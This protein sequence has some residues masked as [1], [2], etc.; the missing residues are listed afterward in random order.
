[1]FKKTTIVTLF[2]VLSFSFSLGWGAKVAVFPFE[3]FSY[4]GY[5]VNF[6]IAE[7]INKAIRSKG[8]KTIG[9]REVLKV[10]IKF[11]QIDVS[12]LSYSLLRSLYDKYECR[13]VL[14]GTIEKLSQSPAQ[15][16]LILRLV[17]GVSGRVVWGKVFFLSAKDQVSILGLNE[18][19]FKRLKKL[20]KMGI[21]QKF[22]LPKVAEEKPL[23][24]AIDVQEVIFSSKCVKPK[25][26]VK[27]LIKLYF[28]GERPYEL[29][30]KVSKTEV[31]NLT[32]VGN[33][34]FIASWVAPEEEK[35][36][37]VYLI[38]KWEKP[39]NT[40]RKIFVGSYWVDKTPP[41]LKL[42]VKGGLK[43]NGKIFVKDVVEIIP[44][45]LEENS[46]IFSPSRGIS[47]WM[48]T[49]TYDPLHK[50]VW[51]EGA[52]GSLP[53]LL[54]W[55]TRINRAILPA[56]KYTIKVF[57]WDLAGNEGVAE[58]SVILV[59]EPPAP[60][61]VI[62][63]SDKGPFVVV[64][65]HKEFLPFV[66]VKVKV[67]NGKNK[68]I[69]QVFKEGTNIS[70]IKEK[71]YFKSEDLI[72]PFYYDAVVEDQLKNEK[73]IKK[74]PIEVKRVESQPGYK[75]WVPEF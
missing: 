62:Y 72:P 31:V 65:L 33:G 46:G 51:S 12:K 50:K 16:F 3:D 27:C 75:T 57:A 37:A 26:S 53:S 22:K 10:L 47:K 71:I 25:A 58:K 7:L 19:T 38:A 68:V 73:I 40:K 36:Y 43:Q 64:E 11:R 55:D 56:G 52:P 66:K 35:K 63:K 23:S 67:Y 6:K 69:A 45:L 8:I 21:K 41:K 14:L 39:L 74:E 59:K 15:L 42:Y 17:D 48:L 70:E 29:K 61:V 5:G 18:L 24:P 1:M 28:S 9:P 2:F 49:I 4:N 44:K 54:V 34:T 30:L 13:Y 60:K 20:V 32:S